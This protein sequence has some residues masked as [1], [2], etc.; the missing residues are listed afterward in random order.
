MDL[1]INAEAKKFTTKEFVTYYSTSVQHQLQNGRKLEDAEVD[2]K[3]TV[4]MPLHA[5]WLVITYNYFTGPDGK[6]VILTNWKRGGISGR[7]DSTTKLPPEDP[8]KSMFI[9]SYPWTI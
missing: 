3:L 6:K 4:I 8:F 9:D 5:Q 2:L 1:T 7:F